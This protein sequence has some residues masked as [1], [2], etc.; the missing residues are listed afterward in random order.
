MA[1]AADR[2]KEYEALFQKSQSYDPSKFQADFEKGYGEATNY[3]KD[4]IESRNKAVAEAQALPAQLREQ[5]YSSPIRNPLAQEALIATRRGG[6]T[7][8]IANLGDLLNARGNKYQDIL[9]KQLGAY[10]TSQQAAQTAAEN[11]WR[12]YQDQLAQEEAARARAAAAS[13]NSWI[14]DLLSGYGQGQMGGGQEEG[15]YEIPVTAPTSRDL[16]TQLPKNDVSGIFKG[17]AGTAG[18]SIAR[19]R[20]QGGSF[21]DYIKNAFSGGAQILNPVYRTTYGLG[22]LSDMIGNLFKRK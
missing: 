9:G 16:L 3:N 1:T 7:Q 13:Q 14:G 4:L 21:G 22:S 20:E 19:A 17:G 5:Y 10:Q 6:A 11:M 12:L 2:L 8:D 18:A 15:S